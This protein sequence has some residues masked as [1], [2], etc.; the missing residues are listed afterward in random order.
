MGSRRKGWLGVGVALA[1]VVALGAW[2]GHAGERL[3]R[4]GEARDGLAREVAAIALEG[5]EPGDF[6]TGSDRFNGEWAVVTCQMAALGLGQVVLEQP[7]L[8]DE[9]LPGLRRCLEDLGRPELRAFGAEAWGEDGHTA[10]RGHAY[11]GYPALALGMGRLVEP[12]GPTAAAHDALIASLDARLVA[13]PALPTYPGEVYPAD[14]AAV[15]GAV[16]LHGRATR[17]DHRGAL[18]PAL[19]WFRARFVDP[20]SGLLFQVMTPDGLRPGGPPRASGTALAAYFLSFADPALSA[21][22]WRALREQCLVTPL[23]LGMIR[24]APPGVS[25]P[26]GDIDS[27]PLIFGISMSAT[28]FS[29]AGA[30]ASGEMSPRDALARTAGTFGVPLTV[31]RRTRFL[32]GGDLGNAILL[33]ML[34]APP[35]ALVNDSEELP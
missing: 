26:V 20:E 14:I 21:S 6:H 2:G 8:R 4:P 18:E 29:L 35:A 17:A 33:A 23:G 34:T 24:E 7:G 30:Q 25:L 27:G 12:E 13:Q 5:V 3:A 32:F 28:G 19:A 31:G 10:A 11:L 15:I 22:L 9:L 1:S 16:A